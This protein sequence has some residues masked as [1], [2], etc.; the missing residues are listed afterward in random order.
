MAFSSDGSTLATCT[1]DLILGYTIQVYQKVEDIW[2]LDSSIPTKL[3]YPSSLSLS[4][5]GNILAVLDADGAT[6]NGQVRT[7]GYDFSTQ[8]WT[9]Y[10]FIIGDNKF[11]NESWMSLS[12]SDDGKVIAISLPL[13]NPDDAGLVRVYRY[14]DSGWKQLGDDLFGSSFWYSYFFG[15]DVS[16]SFDGKRLAIGDPMSNKNGERSGQVT[17]YQLFYNRWEQLGEILNG[18]LNEEFGFS[19]S[20]STYGE[21][22]AV[23]A[24]YSLN[25]NNAVFNAGSVQVYRFDEEGTWNLMGDPLYGEER[26]QNFG[27]SVSL[28][29][30]NVLAVSSFE[31]AGTMTGKVQ[32][33]DYNFQI[34]RWVQSAIIEPRG[35]EFIHFGYVMYLS[36]NGQSLAVAGGA[37]DKGQGSL[38]G[39]T[40][41]YTFSRNTESWEIQRP[42][43]STENRET[44]IAVNFEYLVGDSASDLKPRLLGSGCSQ[45]I[46]VDN[47]IIISESNFMVGIYTL[48][49][50]IDKSK[51][52]R[53]SVVEFDQG[54]GFSA[55]KIKFCSRLDAMEEGG[56]SVNF[57]KESIEITFDLTR[58]ELI[59]I[60]DVMR[61]E[62]KET[63]QNVENYYTIEACRCDGNS[64]YECSSE[65]STLGQNGIVNICIFPMAADVVISNFNMQFVQDEEVVANPVFYGV[66]KPEQGFL[67]KLTGDGKRFKVTTQLVTKFFESPS[68]KIDILGSA[69]LEYKT[70]SGERARKLVDFSSTS[71]DRVLQE[72]TAGSAGKSQYKLEIFLPSGMKN[73]I[74]LSIS[75]ASVLLSIVLIL[76]VTVRKKRK[77]QPDEESDEEPPFNQEFYERMFMQQYANQMWGQPSWRPVDEQVEQVPLPIQALPP[78]IKSVP[79]KQSV[80]SPVRKSLPQRSRSTPRLKSSSYEDYSL[81]PRRPSLQPRRPSLQPRRPS[82]PSRRP[83]LQ[84]RK[85]SLPSRKMS[86]PKRMP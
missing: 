5:N 32:T 58:N 30:M 46:D 66:V 77:K 74:I 24:L 48:T 20:L 22:L 53:S 27:A 15:Y 42:I 57:L 8:S 43:V 52:K 23:G 34:K 1:H 67:T 44:H 11:R 10:G 73:I 31:I 59:F 37:R 70:R 4:G 13:I 63:N 36:T 12:L 21:T 80:S 14:D 85:P 79:R 71:A 61:A 7:Y 55:G 17:V 76:A 84:Q 29:S 86:L 78:R 40:H 51:L 3:S 72:E 81:P 35:R 45:S 38:E 64:S 41:V 49:V 54:A 62:V 56:L 60:S 16:L 19:V 39:R 6:R 18:Y 2:L 26:D 28:T 25:V 69:Y 68:K 65:P 33:F 83:S 50:L 9:L 47:S 75:G 82:L